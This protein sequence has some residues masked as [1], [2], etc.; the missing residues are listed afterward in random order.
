MGGLIV[1][2]NE[3]LNVWLVELLSLEQMLELQLKKRRV[4]KIIQDNPSELT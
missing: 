2:I 3:F 4:K 1:D